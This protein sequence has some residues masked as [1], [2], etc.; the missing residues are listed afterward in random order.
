MSSLDTTAH[1]FVPGT[2]GWTASTLDD[3]A[4]EARWAQG[5]FEIIDGVLTTMPP[6]YFVGGNALIELVF[7]LK[8]HLS[9]LGLAGHFGSEADIILDEDRV[10]VA[11]AVWLTPEDQRRQREAT[12]RAGRTD[13]DRTRILVPPTLVIES[14]SPGHERHGEQTKRRWYAEFG[15]PNYWLLDAFSKSLRCLKLEAGRYVVDAEGFGSD[16]VRP[17]LFPDLTIPLSRL[18]LS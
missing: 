6:A 1:P 16:E 3:P 17:T 8:T 9:K 5:R 7:I 2:T 11:D 14:V 10:V 12:Q 4:V 15:V 18:W 13:A